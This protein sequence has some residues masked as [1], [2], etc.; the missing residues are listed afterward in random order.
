MGGWGWSFLLT[1][2]PVPTVAGSSGQT[3][4]G[5][6]TSAPSF[7]FDF[8]KCRSLSVLREGSPEARDTPTAQGTFPTMRLEAQQR[9]D[10]SL[11]RG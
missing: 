1:P 3:L 11:S 2:T 5:S 8:A 7:N 10:V 4:G 6:Q 9:Q